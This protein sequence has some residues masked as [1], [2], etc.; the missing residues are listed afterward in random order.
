MPI[1]ISISVSTS[2]NVVA[3]L[4]DGAGGL[5]Y[6]H[7]ARLARECSAAAVTLGQARHLLGA[8]ARDLES[9]DIPAT[10]RGDRP[11]RRGAGHVI[12]AWTVATSCILI[13]AWSPPA[14][15]FMTSPP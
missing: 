3:N 4:R 8:R 13:A 12:R 6:P 1:P 10:P 14:A 11:V 9:V 15:M 7:A 5:S 2:V